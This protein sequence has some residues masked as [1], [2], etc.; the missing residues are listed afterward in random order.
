MIM[1]SINPKQL[2]DFFE[3]KY[4]C[5]FEKNIVEKTFDAHRTDVLAYIDSINSIAITDFI[6]YIKSYC[7]CQPI[8][9]ADVVQFSDF[10]DATVELCRRVA[11]S[12][13]SG[14]RFKDVGMLLFS[15]DIMRKDA[16]L[17]KY[18]ENHIKTAEALGLSFTGKFLSDILSS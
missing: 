9:A 13:N 16:A 12:G 6:E 2:A 18:G 1:D 11:E 3:H 15:D 4:E 7:K 8:M 5:S 10:E 14:L 17:N